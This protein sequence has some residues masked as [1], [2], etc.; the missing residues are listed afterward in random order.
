MTIEQEGVLRGIAIENTYSIMVEEKS[1]ENILFDKEGEIQPFVFFLEP[2]ES[3]TE[4][5]INEMIGYFAKYDEYEKCHQ[6]KLLKN[7]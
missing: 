7:K 2:G 1:F 3:P 4:D 5:E 6:L